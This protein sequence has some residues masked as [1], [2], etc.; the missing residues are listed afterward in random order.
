MKASEGLK[1]INVRGNDICILYFHMQCIYVD[2]A[3]IGYHIILGWR[4][5]LKTFPDLTHPVAYIWP[6]RYY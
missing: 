6:Q 2:D 1:Q 3:S 5:F 4:K